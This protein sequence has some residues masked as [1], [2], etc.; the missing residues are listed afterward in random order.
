MNIPVKHWVRIYAQKIVSF[1]GPLVIVGFEKNQPLSITCYILIPVPA[2][3]QIK[4]LCVD[5]IHIFKLWLF[6]QINLLYIKKKNKS[7]DLTV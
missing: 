4:T 2:K 1:T 3:T 5:V 6:W 7:S